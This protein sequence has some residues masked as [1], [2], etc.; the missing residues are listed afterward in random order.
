MLACYGRLGA[1]WSGPYRCLARPAPGSNDAAS[2]LR[3][4]QRD[5]REQLERAAGTSTAS[6]AARRGLMV[7][8][9]VALLWA[10]CVSV[11]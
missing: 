10:D 3:P 11:S 1:A 6:S 7:V 9:C 8:D 4:N 2:K 5:N